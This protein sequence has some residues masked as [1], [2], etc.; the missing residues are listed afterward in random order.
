[1]PHKRNTTSL[2]RGAKKGHL[3]PG[4]SQLVYVEH[5]HIPRLPRAG[6]L[7]VLQTAESNDASRID[8]HA[9]MPTDLER[10]RQ[11]WVEAPWSHFSLAYVEAVFKERIY[12]AYMIH[13]RAI[14]SA[15]SS[16]FL[17][18]HGVFVQF[19]SEM[20]KGMMSS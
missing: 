15:C 19:S 7:V 10:G 2:R 18:R 4:S 6:R 13:L 3:Y 9:T 5:E 17:S 20:A 12:G 16:T 8:L 1:M 14:E 11:G